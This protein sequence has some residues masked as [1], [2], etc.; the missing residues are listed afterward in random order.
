[1]DRRINPFSE[2]YV[3][4]TI[5]ASEFVKIF[6]SYVIEIAEELF[7]PGN[8]ILKGVQGCGKSM[9]LTLLKPELRGAYRRSG[10]PF[11]LKGRRHSQFI[12]AGINLTRSRAIDVGQRTIKGAEDARLLSL[13]F[14]DFFNYWIVGD[15]LRSVEL[16]A[17][18]L[19]G[20]IAREL[21]MRSDSRALDQF[22]VE[23]S[24]S[25]SWFGSLKGIGTFQELKGR[26]ASRIQTYFKFFSFGIPE[27]PR[28]IQ[29]TRTAVGA[30]LS[31]TSEALSKSGVVPDDVH[32]LYASISTRNSRKSRRNSSRVQSTGQ[33]FTRRC[34]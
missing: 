14:G 7:L 21:K 29:E 32:I 17:T 22:A 19:E 9:L 33:Y 26:I 25:A 16:Y 12:S 27:L 18:E 3:T 5:P 8:V 13:F 28:E 10:E 2:L 1:M 31:E 30:P 24:G 11:P 34:R 6:S 20:Q 4:E 15:L 23:V